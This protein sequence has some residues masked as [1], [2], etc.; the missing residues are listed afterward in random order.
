MTASGPTSLPSVYVGDANE[1]LATNHVALH[2][3]GRDED[4]ALWTKLGL[5]SSTPDAN[6]VMVGN[7]TGTSTWL[8]GL[9]NAYISAG[10]A[11][12]YSK[13]NLA[14]SIAS[15][16]LVAN[17]V[18]Q[19]ALSSAF[20]GTTTSTSYVDI[21]GGSATLTTTGGVLVAI[22][23]Q[24]ANMTAATNASY[25]ALS[26]DAAT[27]VGEV[28]TVPANASQF[29]QVAIYLFT[30]VSAASHTVK[31]RYKVSASTSNNFSGLLLLLE[32]K[33]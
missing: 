19:Q 26:L 10:A 13:L 20:S 24:C 28:V 11:I 7:G 5:G 9:T 8:A 32:L 31:A 17:S 33:K 6:E 15:A 2:V 12:A 14:A 23:V 18:T 16:D 27:E 3:D 22:A 4:R 21:T 30:G 29:V 25:L 1:A